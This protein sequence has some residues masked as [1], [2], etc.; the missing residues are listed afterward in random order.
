MSDHVN[1]IRDPRRSKLCTSFLFSKYILKTHVRGMLYEH[2]GTI[3]VSDG[4][5]SS[6][7]ERQQ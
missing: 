1:L 3:H 4:G 5:F 2:L 6:W 7:L